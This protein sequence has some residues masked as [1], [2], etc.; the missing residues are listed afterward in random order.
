MKLK[1]NISFFKLKK[2]KKS[3]HFLNRFCPEKLHPIFY[4]RILNR[5]F[6]EK[7]SINFFHKTDFD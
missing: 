1:K 5:F 4:R 6:Y 7:F 3:I 2:K